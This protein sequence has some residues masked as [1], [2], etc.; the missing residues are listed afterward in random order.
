MAHLFDPFQVRGVTLRNRIGV[1]PMC[2]YSAVDGMANDWHL[3]HLGSRAAG[4]AGLVIIEA[5][6]VEPRGRITPYDLG[7]WS[8][9]Q[10]EPL[11]RAARFITEQ[12]AVA[13]IQIAHAGRK[14]STS[15]PWDARKAMVPVEEGGWTVVGPSA[16]PFSEQYPMPAE[17]SSGEI[18]QVVAAFREGARR[19]RDAGFQWLEL[20]AS[21]GYLL[22]SFMSP[23]SNQ[24]TDE[25]GG[26]YENRIRFALEVAR[27]TRAVWPEDRVLTARF[28][29]TDWVEGGWTLEETIELSRR[30]KVEGFD[31]I[32]CSSGGLSPLQQIPAGAGY[33]VPFSESVRQGAQIPTA[34]VGLITQP[35]QADS[36]VRNQRADIILLGRELLRNPYWPL[37][38]A[39]ALGHRDLAP[40]PPQYLRAF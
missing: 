33:Q 31:L 32:D 17:L 19:A 28:S 30:F 4:G 39:V 3:V 26:T 37:H 8:D 21:H 18:A 5:T 13:G 24:R 6:A 35:M 25:Y 15:R 34:T 38:A 11:A 36:L 10:V 9:D 23:L 40:V 1:S 2:Q 16:I 29:C 20:H 22:H 27:A 14:A 12:G 7:I